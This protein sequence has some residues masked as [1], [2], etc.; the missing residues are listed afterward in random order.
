MKT[1]P[2][3]NSAAKIALNPF[4]AVVKARE[5]AKQALSK[6][7]KAKLLVEKKGKLLARSKK[8]ASRKKAF[9]KSAVAEGAVT[10]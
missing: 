2:L 4:H 8:F 3:R 9:Y 5:E 6:E 1:N 10:F 7:A